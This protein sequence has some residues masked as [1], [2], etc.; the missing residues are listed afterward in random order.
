M[1]GSL[2]TLI[3]AVLTHRLRKNISSR[4]LMPVVVNGLVIGLMLSLLYQ[5]PLF[6]TILTVSLGEAGVCYVFGR[7]AYQEC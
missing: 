7:T 1:F 6:M 2:A 3:A 5:L 4:T